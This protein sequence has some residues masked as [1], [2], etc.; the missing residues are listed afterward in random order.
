VVSTARRNIEAFSRKALRRDW[1]MR[2]RQAGVVGEKF[3]PFQRVGIYVPGGTAPLVSTALMTITLAKTAG[4]PE[5][6]VSTPCGPDGAINPALLFA[7]RAAGA[8][9]VYRLGGAQAIAALALGTPSIPR[10][11]K[12]FGPGNAYVVAAKRLLFGHVAID[13]LPGPSEVMVL[14][15]ETARPDWVAADLIAQAEHG[16]GHERVWLVTTSLAL[17]RAVQREIKR[18]VPARE[19]RA[20]IEK[21]LANHGWLIHVRS[22]EDAAELANELAPEHCEIM[23]RHP[24]ELA[25]KIVAAGAIFLGGWTPTVLGDYLAGPSHTLPTG[26][27]APVSP[28][29]P[30]TNFKGAPASC[31]M[32]APRCANPWM[33]SEGL[34]HSRDS[35]PM[36]T[37]RPS[38][39]PGKP[40]NVDP[41][42]NGPNNVHRQPAKH[43]PSGFTMPASKS[44]TRKTAVV[45]PRPGLVRPLVRR[46]KAYV[47]GE[48]PRIPGLIKL[49]TNENPYPPAPAVLAA[50]RKAVDDRL[51]LYPNPTAQALREKLARFHRCARTRSS[52]GTAA[53][54][55][56][57]WRPARLLSPPP[58]R[59]ARPPGQR[60][61]PSNSSLRATRSTRSWRTSMA[62]PRIRSR[63]PWIFHCRPLPNCAAVAGGISRP[64]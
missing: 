3:D 61:P 41:N 54:N 26:G 48:Q 32:I 43:G 15:D 40:R 62:R 63:Y 13:L 12:I 27:A 38:A 18:Q 42:G 52:S 44:T 64:P 2:N 28:G 6:A 60:N 55:C 21:A 17:L 14:A 49:N 25:G 8:T 39:C 30:W 59:K 45:Q 33:W 51:R 5:I 29:S 34:R 24:A 35:K 22:L 16:S 50:I 46:L 36:P 47:P 37:R 4:C 53:M 31:S 56:S 23:T 10:V 19:R 1:S 11:Q 7:I 20:L 9:E 57:H 58:G